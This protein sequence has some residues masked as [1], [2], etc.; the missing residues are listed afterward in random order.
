MK[1]RSMERLLPLPGKLARIEYPFSIA[2]ERAATAGEGRARAVGA[3]R[4][5]AIAQVDVVGAVVG[6]PGARVAAGG[7]D[8]AIVVDVHAAAVAGGVL[9]HAAAARAAVGHR[10]PVAEQAAPVHGA[11]LVDGAVGDRRAVVVGVD[12]AS[13]IA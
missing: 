8:R 3:G 1:T 9:P 10:A 4:V 6:G 2:G 5:P 12:S 7:G 13:G 11:V